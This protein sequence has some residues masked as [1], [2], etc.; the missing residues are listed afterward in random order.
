MGSSSL[1]QFSPKINDVLKTSYKIPYLF[2]GDYGK[3]S[4]ILNTKLPAKK[5]Q[6]NS[7]EP[8]Q[9]ASEEVV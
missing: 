3:C 1:A 7:A 8:D 4:K 6:A 5:A 9:T 2:S